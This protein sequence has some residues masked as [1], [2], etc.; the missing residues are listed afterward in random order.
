MPLSR[1]LIAEFVGTALLLACVVGS[2]IMGV[3]LSGGKDGVAL[4]GPLL[5]AVGFGSAAGLPP[6]PASTRAADSAIAHA[7]RTLIRPPTPD[8]P[9]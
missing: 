5:D 4:L 6:Q 8:H 3:A 9:W 2:G 1:R 7:R